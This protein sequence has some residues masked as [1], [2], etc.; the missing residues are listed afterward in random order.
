MPKEDENLP[1]LTAKMQQLSWD[2]LRCLSVLSEAGSVQS[3]STRLRL[4]ATTLLRRIRRLS[5]ALG[6]DLIER[7]EGRYQLSELGAKVAEYGASIDGKIH[8]LVRHLGRDDLTLRGSVRVTALPSI[9]SRVIAPGLPAFRAIYPD[10]TLEL[11]GAS[12]NLSLAR[13]EADIAL[14]FALPSGPELVGRK[15]NDFPFYPCSKH[16]DL[17]MDTE[18]APWLTYV[19]PMAHLPEAQ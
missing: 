9:M 14:R 4:D 5:V 3:A 10:I 19:E 15:L 8:D 18:K 7:R 17:P 16:M 11:L 1:N 6:V 13:D 12:R 2:D